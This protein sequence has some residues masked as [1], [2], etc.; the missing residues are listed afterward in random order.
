MRKSKL[1]SKSRLIA[2]AGLAAISL[3]VHAMDYEE[4]HWHCRDMGY[5]IGSKYHQHCVYEET[6]GKYGRR[7]ISADIESNARIKKLQAERRA[8]E[9]QRRMRAEA[10]KQRRNQATNQW[11]MEFGLQ[12]MQR[13]SPSNN[14]HQ[15]RAPITC[16][17]QPD[18]VGGYIVNCD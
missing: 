13:G 1:L 3:K 9:I 7:K 5:T 2:I 15:R 18:G 10:E 8:L 12:L 6:N 11:L 16:F 4:A 17:A 14:N